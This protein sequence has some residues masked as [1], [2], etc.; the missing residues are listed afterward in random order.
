MINILWGVI[1]CFIEIFL[2]VLVIFC[3]A[4]QNILLDMPKK[5]KKLNT[6]S[7]KKKIKLKK[8]KYKPIKGEEREN[9]LL[10]TSYKENDFKE[11]MEHVHKQLKRFSSYSCKDKDLQSLLEKTYWNISRL[12]NNLNSDNYTNQEISYFYNFEL[13]QF[14]ILLGDGPTFTVDKE[15]Y[16]KLYSC[17]KTINKKATKLEEHIKEWK[18][19][20]I[21]VKFDALIECIEG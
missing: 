6:K 13:E 15:V 12:A 14:F 4:N 2:V 11:F 19:F 17:L 20:Q 18:N 10:T 8:K 7:G 1:I 21:I 5:D 16:E 3:S 9:I